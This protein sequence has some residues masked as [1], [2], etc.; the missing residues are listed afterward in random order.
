MLSNEPG[1]QVGGRRTGSRV[2]LVDDDPTQLKLSRI[3]LESAGYTV[4]TARNADEALEHTLGELPDAI[5]SDV[6]MGEVDGFNLCRKLRENPRFANVPV[7]LLSAHCD[8][9]RDRDLSAKV[10][11]TQLVA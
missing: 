3:R 9:A 11:A 5:L 8:E 10:G 4:Q 2:L 1:E 6:W 7:I